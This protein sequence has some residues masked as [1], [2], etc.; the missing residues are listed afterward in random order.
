MNRFKINGIFKTFC[1][2][3]NGREELIKSVHGLTIEQCLNI[4]GMEKWNDVSKNITVNSGRN[5]L[6]V[7]R[8]AIAP[9]KKINRLPN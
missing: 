2:D 8:G 9:A 6:R 7:I 4:L 3:M 5:K 1:W